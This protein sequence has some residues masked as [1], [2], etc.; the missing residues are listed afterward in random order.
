M[1]DTTVPY[2][3]L[4]DRYEKVKSG[5]PVEKVLEEAKAYYQTRQAGQ[6][7]RKD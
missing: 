1:K 6:K 5:E 4:L 2:T 7:T 3:V